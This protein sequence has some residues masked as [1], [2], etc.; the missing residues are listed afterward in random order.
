M[1]KEN[2]YMENLKELYEEASLQIDV[3]NLYEA[4]K[5]IKKIKDENSENEKLFIL[6]GKYFGE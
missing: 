5:I 4:D 1:F 3:K 2:W 6:E